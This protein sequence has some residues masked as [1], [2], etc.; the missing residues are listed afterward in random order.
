MKSWSFRGRDIHVTG[1]DELFAGGFSDADNPNSWLEGVS[2]SLR[3][4]K[5]SLETQVPSGSSRV[6]R[7]LSGSSRKLEV[8]SLLEDLACEPAIAYKLSQSK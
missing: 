2:T 4:S 1:P 3:V 5:V 7:G 6:L 8:K